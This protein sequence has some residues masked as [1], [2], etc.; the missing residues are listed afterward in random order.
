MDD[1]LEPGT[2]GDSLPLTPQCGGGDDMDGKAGLESVCDGKTDPGLAG[3]GPV[4]Q[5]CPPVASGRGKS[6]DE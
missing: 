2:G 3:S 4:G 1:D 6:T 5:E